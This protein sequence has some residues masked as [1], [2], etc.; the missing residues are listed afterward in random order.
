M[1]VAHNACILCMYS[2]VYCPELELSNGH[3]RGG[4]GGYLSR[5]W[6]E[7]DEGYMLFGP[8]LRR[9]G[10]DGQWSGSMPTCVSE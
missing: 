4:R 10:I 6:Y 1:K 8:S 3:I 2:A 5:S 7:C 9:C